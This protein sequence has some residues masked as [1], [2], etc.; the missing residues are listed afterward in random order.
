MIKIY[1]IFQQ[2][3]LFIFLLL[4]FSCKKFVEIPPPTTE[5]LASNVFVNQ[6]AA[7]AAQTAIYTGMAT[8]QESYSIANQN[9]MLADEL[10]NYSS[11]VTY[12]EFYTNSMAAKDITQPWQNAYSF[13]YQANAV[14]SGLQN[15]SGISAA[16]TQQLRGEAEFIRAFWNFYLTMS[17]GAVP[18]VTS[19]SYSINESLARTPQNL[20]YQQIISDLTSAE[21]LLNINYVDVTDTTIT[22]DRVR[23]NKSAAAALLARVYLF[24]GKYDSAE[25]AASSVINNASLYQLSLGLDTVFLSISPEAIWQ[26]PPV[27]PSSNLATT[28]GRFFI[29]LTAPGSGPNN[30]SSISQQLLSA[31]ENG[32]NR[33]THWINSIV[34]GVDTFYYPFKYKLYSV[35]NTTGSIPEYTMVLRLGEQYLIR[36]EA[37]AQLGNL[38]NAVTDLNTI[39]NRAGL[40]NYSGSMD[41]ASILTAI[42]HERQVEL[43]TEW[44]ARWYDLQR[45]NTI[46]NVMSIVTPLKGGTWNP[47]WALYPIPL[48]EILNDPNLIQNPNY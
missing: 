41:Q 30:C 40:A 39:R 32:D 48:T 21:N 46:N 4:A 5:I 1:K 42:W 24:A 27:Q 25:Q 13:I 14:I 37:Y 3:F 38:G 43:F 15:Y 7:T 47:S 31:F 17:C 9:G 28:D 18:L 2:L 35:P 10:T 11:A 12:K 8:K 26:I 23:P 34:V 19:P 29:L 44:G 45:T 6:D 36:A 22:A 16:A 20:I 33:M